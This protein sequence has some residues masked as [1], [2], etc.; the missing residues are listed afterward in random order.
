MSFSWKFREITAFDRVPHYY[1]SQSQMFLYILL[2]EICKNIFAWNECFLRV[3]EALGRIP[4]T[5]KKK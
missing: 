2:P 3:F 5:L 1:G 4:E